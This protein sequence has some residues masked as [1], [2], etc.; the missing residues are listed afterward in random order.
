MPNRI[1]KNVGSGLLAQSWIGILGLVALP[2]FARGL[3]A[4]RYGLLA[5][6]LA[7]INIAGIADLGVGRAASKYLAEDY[8]RKETFRTQQFVSTAMTVTVVMGLIGTALLFLLSPILVDFAFRIPSGMQREAKMAF[9]ITGAGL[10][11]V[12]LRI[13]FD[14]ILAGHHRVAI[15]SF[16]NM[17]ISTLRVGLSI[18]AILTGYSL[19]AVLI[20]NVAMSYLHAAGLWWYTRRHFAGHVKFALGWDAATARQL[21][22]LGLVSTLSVI[23]ANV[24]FL[25]ADRFI[26]AAF[27]PLAF[28]GYY[29]MAFD[30]ASRQAYVSNS[31]AA[32][33]FPVF[34]GHG[35][36]SVKDLES[37]YLQATKAVAVGTTG[38]AMLLAVFGRPLL[39]YWVDPSFGA[40]STSSLMVLAIASLL[41]CYVQILYTVIMAASPRPGV[42]VRVFSIAVALHVGVSLVFLRYWNIVGVAAAF[43]L[44]YVFVF[45][46]LLW[47]VTKNLVRTKV[48]SVIWRSFVGSWA[49]AIGLGIILRFFVLPVVRNLTSV[50]FAF[51]SGY[52]LYL[53]CCAMIAYNS[54]ERDYFRDLVRSRFRSSWRKSLALLGG[55]P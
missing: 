23:M 54:Q 36:T 30:I 44:A 53:G 41:A 24:V 19:L 16:G 52:L 26:I 33:F 55:E 1:I 51:A 22:A 42:C 48:R 32:A 46:Y 10:L 7:L 6:N 28:T 38:L 20:I 3:G 18:T 17:I 4:D 14:G 47:W 2:V 12:L 25:Y 11:A 31:V 29:T 5:L 37:S 15:L 49:S 8:E 43:V 39:T 27:L 50:L 45:C 21:L 35:A 34:S 9:W 13:L 40:N